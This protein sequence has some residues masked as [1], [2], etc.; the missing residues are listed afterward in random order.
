VAQS[1]AEQRVELSNFDFAPTKIHL[2][3]GQAT[4]LVLSNLASGGHDFAAPEFFAAARVEPAD[5]ALVRTARSTCPPSRRRTVH[6]VPAAGTYK[7]TCTHMMHAMF[8][9]KGTDRR[10][11]THSPPACG[12]G[13]DHLQALPLRR[14][15]PSPCARLPSAARRARLVRPAAARGRHVGVL[16][17]AAGARLVAAARSPC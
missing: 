11:V 1:G 4:T 6:L 5:A 16:L 12:R 3:A 2:R 14:G 8:G 9:M 7:L 15:Y 13:E 10:R 17:A